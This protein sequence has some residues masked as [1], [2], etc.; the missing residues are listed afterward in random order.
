[1][2]HI[3]LMAEEAGKYIYC[4]HNNI[5]NNQCV[6]VCELE[7]KEYLLV[8]DE[9]KPL[10]TVGWLVVFYGTSTLVGYPYLPIPPLRQDMSQGQFL[11][12]G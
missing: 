12:G 11:S 2:C 1:M 7:T 3:L 6:C 9:F 5:R 4:H 8:T 10:N